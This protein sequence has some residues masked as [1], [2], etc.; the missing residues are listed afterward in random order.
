MHDKP[1]NKIENKT[2]E[3]D[4]DTE[5]FY[6]AEE[7]VPLYICDQNALIA[8]YGSEIELNR[9]I[10]SPRGDGIYSARLPLLD[11]ALPFWVYGRGLLFL[12]AYYLLAETVNNNTWRPITSVMIDIHRG[13]YADLEHRY[14]RIS[15]EE[16]GIELKN[17]HDGHS[18]RLQDVHGLKWIRL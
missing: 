14:S 6:V 1:V 2:E 9:T 10:V 11:V 17:G 7:G 12:D 15:V 4:V 8:Y 13:K 5:K 16:K 18:L 3:R